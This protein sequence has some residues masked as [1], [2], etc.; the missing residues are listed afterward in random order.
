[1]IAAQI[2]GV[3]LS[4]IKDILDPNKPIVESPT[5]TPTPTPAP[6]PMAT[7]VDDSKSQ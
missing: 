3:P 5:P 7:E 4:K 1:M 2:K 6:A